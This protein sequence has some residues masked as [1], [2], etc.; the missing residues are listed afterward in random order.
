MDKT[1]ILLA[2]DYVISSENLAELH[3]ETGVGYDWLKAFRRGTVVVPGAD[4]VE[5]ILRHAGYDIEGL[6]RNPTAR[7]APE[8]PP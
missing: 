8:T 3:R 4:K 1:L 7:P 6:R 5:R 2:R